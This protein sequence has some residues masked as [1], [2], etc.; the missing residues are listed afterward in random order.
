MVVPYLHTFVR[1]DI[2]SSRADQRELVLVSQL[3]KLRNFVNYIA[4]RD[5]EVAKVGGHDDWTSVSL[6]HRQV[7]QVHN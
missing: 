4:L 3:S 7:L 1:D 6:S 5:W 2:Y